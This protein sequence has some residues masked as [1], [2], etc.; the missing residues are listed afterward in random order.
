MPDSP[1]HKVQ[2]IQA[3]LTRLIDLYKYTRARLCGCLEVD[4][5]RIIGRLLPSMG[6][7]IEW[8][9]ERGPESVTILNGAR[10]PFK[11]REHKSRPGKEAAPQSSEEANKSTVRAFI[12]PEQ[13]RL[14]PYHGCALSAARTTLSSNISNQLLQAFTTCSLI[15]ISMSRWSPG[16][17]SASVHHGTKTALTLSFTQ[18][19][20]IDIEPRVRH[21]G[22]SSV[23]NTK[24]SRNLPPVQNNQHSRQSPQ[25]V[26]KD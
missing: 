18:L 2:E 26:S 1:H 8:D 23:H 6:T 17:E 11:I 19:T 21:H 16:G 3:C 13:R 22:G 20:T 7:R 25:R 24:A 10:S 5:S 4:F 12:G 14:G 15:V 9:G